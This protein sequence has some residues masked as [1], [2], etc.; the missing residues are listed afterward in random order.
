MKSLGLSMANVDFC[1]DGKDAV[2]LIQRN[3]EAGIE[4]SLVLTDFQM[5]GY[6][7]PKT[8]AA[9]KNLGLGQSSPAIVG[10]SG[11]DLSIS[12]MEGLRS[13]MNEVH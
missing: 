7:G 3:Y 9:I 1:M 12:E 8:T 4:Y 6:D 2:E 10:L 5:P 13:G 11:N